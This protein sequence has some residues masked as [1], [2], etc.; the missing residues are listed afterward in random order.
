MSLSLTLKYIH[1]HVIM[2]FLNS[3]QAFKVMYSN[4]MYGN[5]TK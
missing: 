1:I 5:A 3:V 2:L 4:A